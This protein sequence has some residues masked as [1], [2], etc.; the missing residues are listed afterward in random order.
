MWLVSEYGSV[1]LGWEVGF[2]EGLRSRQ[3]V[4][5]EWSCTVAADSVRSVSV[6]DRSNVSDF[7]WPP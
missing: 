3:F 2:S 5:S 1:I 4:V 7:P 6:S